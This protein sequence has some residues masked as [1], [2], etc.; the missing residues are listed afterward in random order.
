MSNVN[1]MKDSE[2]DSKSSGYT[3][4]YLS[5]YE[6]THN[7]ENEL[8]PANTRIDNLRELSPQE[9]NL[10]S[11]V[12]NQIHNTNFTE[13]QGVPEPRINQ[14]LDKSKSSKTSSNMIT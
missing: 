3:G 5:E 13:G 12:L 6:G 10:P 8:R 1:F 2:S 14:S 4:T 9:Q 11:N 7:F